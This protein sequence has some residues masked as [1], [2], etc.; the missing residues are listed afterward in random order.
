VRVPAA[1]LAEGVLSGHPG[2]DYHVLRLLE[3]V[4]IDAVDEELGHAA[5]QLR[6]GVLRDRTGTTPSGVD[7]IVVAHADLAASN[8]DVMIITS[9]E[10]DVTAL[11]VHATNVARLSIRTV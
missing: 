4:G 8:H 11:A 9:D 3:I 6:A 10:G 1:V 7:A 5:G 2:R